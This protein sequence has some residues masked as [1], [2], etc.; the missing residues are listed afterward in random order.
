MRSFQRKRNWRSVIQSKPVL[1]ILIILLFFFAWGVM[2][3]MGKMQL[4]VENRKIAEEKLKD[5]EEK[6]EKLSSDIDKLNTENGVE[7]SIRLKFG[8][9]KEG[10]G[11]IVV[12]PDPNKPEEKPAKSS[13]FFSFIKNWFK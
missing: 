5:L 2:G 3:F 13:G 8:L 6:K 11:V 10:E 4:T 9:A 1:T 7:E 12:V